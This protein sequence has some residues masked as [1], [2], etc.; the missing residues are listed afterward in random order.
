ML[1][2]GFI[3]SFVWGSSKGRLTADDMGF[4]AAMQLA[5]LLCASLRSLRS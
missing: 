5:F 3:H 4:D 2:A 1:G